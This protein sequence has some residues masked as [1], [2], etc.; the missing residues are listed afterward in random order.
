MFLIDLRGWGKHFVAIE[1]EDVVWELEKEEGNGSRKDMP[2]K[3]KS[4]RYIEI[5]VGHGIF[6]M[7]ENP[8]GCTKSFVLYFVGQPGL[9]NKAALLLSPLICRMDSQL[10]RHTH[11]HT[12][13]HT[14]IHIHTY[15]GHL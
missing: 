11:T 8:K 2:V 10:S 6:W 7:V 13:T 15:C 14:H 12:H 1:E 4:S 5:M 3:G 9:N